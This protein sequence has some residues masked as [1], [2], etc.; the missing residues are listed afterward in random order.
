MADE[1]IS[2]LEGDMENVKHHLANLT[3][4]AVECFK[5]IKKKFGAGRER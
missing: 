3:D 1:K 5:M 4:Y 2:G